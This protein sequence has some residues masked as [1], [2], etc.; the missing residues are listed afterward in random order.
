MRASRRSLL[1]ILCIQSPCGFGSLFKLCISLQCGYGKPTQ[2]TRNTLD[3]D[4]TMKKKK[5]TAA[6][7]KPEA[8]TVI[9]GDVRLHLTEEDVLASLRTAVEEDGVKPVWISWEDGSK[10]MPISVNVV[11][12]DT[13]I[14]MLRDD[15]TFQGQVFRGEGMIPALAES[16]DYRDTLPTFSWAIAEF[17]ADGEMN[18][19]VYQIQIDPW[20]PMP[21]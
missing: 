11:E 4:T 18:E 5:E 6:G 7:A 3:K 13:F 1:L 10:V 15:M 17:L 14:E 19:L 20:R 21:Y 9:Y 12:I 8:W 16:K 2:V